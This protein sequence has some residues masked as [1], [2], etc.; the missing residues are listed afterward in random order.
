M[1][2]SEYLE[3]VTAQMRCK[4]ARGMV[5]KEL[6]AHIEDQADTYMEYG[7][8][9]E[10]AYKKAV[11]QMG[12]PI[13]VGT[14][15]DR[16]HRPDIDKKALF[17]ICLLSL[18]GGV[19]Y[20]WSMDMGDGRMFQMGDFFEHLLLDVLPGMFL[21]WLIIKIDYTR[22]ARHPFLFS[23]VLVMIAPY[24][25]HFEARGKYG[26]VFLSFTLIA[27]LFGAVLHK[28]REYKLMGMFFGFLWLMFIIL[29]YHFSGRANIANSVNLLVIGMFLLGTG[30]F[31]DWFEAGKK[32]SVAM[33]L[34]LLC[35]LILLGGFG[36]VLHRFFGQSYV[37]HRLMGWI[38][39]DQEGNYIFNVIR[40]QAANA[41]FFKGSGNLTGV[42]N[43]NEYFI[44]NLISRYGYLAAILVAVLLGLLFLVLLSGVKKQQN[45][46]GTLMGIAAILTLC[47]PVVEHIAYNLSL[48]PTG[49]LILPFF[50]GT[51]ADAWMQ[52]DYCRGAILSY[53]AAMGICLSVY[54]SR[55]IVAEQDAIPKLRL[56][57][58]L[59][60]Q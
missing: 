12:D 49:A 46:L 4:R 31:K 54:R 29:L 43:E 23:L 32:K 56:K 25:E 39:A 36:L 30:A 35:E 58:K 10:E 28:L 51:G 44:I 24:A 33:Y 40:T 8:P 38:N 57:L 18:A 11:A 6:K 16:L 14:D 59:E 50:S 21:M 34:G 53:Y 55:N 15:M 60:R 20:R 17:L 41:G 48:I 5:E 47:I 26:Y 1:Q 13:Q 37:R 42:G 2:V 22:I 7:I 9:K 45:R 19:L 52:G 3:A 27:I